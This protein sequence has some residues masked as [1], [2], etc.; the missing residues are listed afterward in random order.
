M[1]YARHVA[2]PGAFFVSFFVTT[3]DARQPIMHK[4]AVPVLSKNFLAPNAS[5]AE[6]EKPV[7]NKIEI[8]TTSRYVAAAPTA[9]GLAPDSLA[10]SGCVGSPRLHP[11]PLCSPRATARPASLQPAC[12]PQCHGLHCMRT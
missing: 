2:M 7:A 8:D 3:E 10:G 11:P 5:S 12:L 4:T 9:A 6:T 1:Y